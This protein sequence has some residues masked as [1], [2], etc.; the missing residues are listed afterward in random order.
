MGM[1][2]PSWF[3]IRSLDKNDKNQDEEGVKES[4]QYILD[5]VKA[6]VSINDRRF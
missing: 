4:A 5:M 3:D 6:E 1:G 2:M